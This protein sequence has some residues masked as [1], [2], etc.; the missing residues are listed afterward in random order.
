MWLFLIFSL[1]NLRQVPVVVSWQWMLGNVVTR[2]PDQTTRRK[3]LTDKL[4][5]I[6]KERNRPKRLKRENF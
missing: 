5:Y 6:V 1:P 2:L 4:G 3:H